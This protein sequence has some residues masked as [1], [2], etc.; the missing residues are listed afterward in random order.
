MN[1]TYHHLHR[2][3][4]CGDSSTSIYDNVPTKNVDELSCLSFRDKLQM[5]DGSTEIF[6]T[7]YVT[8]KK[9]FRPLTKRDGNDQSIRKM[10]GKK[11]GF[12]ENWKKFEEI[13][14][15][16]NS[17][18]ELRGTL[19]LPSNVNNIFNQLVR[20][21]EERHERLS[22]EPYQSVDILKV[23]E[24]ETIEKESEGEEF[25]RMSPAFISLH[26]LYRP[27]KFNL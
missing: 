19:K 27:E 10:N 26:R 7:N 24:G 5:F 16:R 11:N 21:S 20:I 25:I 4:W 17:T 22:P 14:N 13:S 3:T 23:F 12:K 2:L 18:I 1:W 8:K 6:K 15:R 9:L